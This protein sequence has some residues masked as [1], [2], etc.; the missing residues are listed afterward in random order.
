MKRDESPFFIGYLPAPKRL[1]GFLAV[2]ILSLLA[3][4]LGAGLVTGATQD[5][6]GPGDFRFDLGRQTVTGMVELRPYP[7]IR[8]T[9]GNEHIAT[10]HTLM[11]T[12]QG[13]RGVLEQATPLDGRLATVSGVLLRR[14][15]LD[16]LQVA[17]GADGLIAAEGA[18]MSTGAREPLGRWRIAG[19]IC[20]GKCLAG[21]M[22]PG[23][24]IAHRACANLCLIGGVPPV[25]VAARPVAGHEFFLVAGPDGGPMPDA[26]L[27]HVG[28]YVLLEGEIEMAGDL[29]VLRVDPASLELA[30]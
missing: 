24:G 28:A 13:K 26:L 23:R 22:R 11:L 19:E 14:G 7:L 29:P 8:V 20:D 3:G 6:P 25:F 5:D 4:F 18:A 17:G 27:A 1:A 16:V 2:C 12:G 15:D 21:A 30:P 9:A 10:G